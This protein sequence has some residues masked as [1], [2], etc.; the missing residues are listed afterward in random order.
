MQR[1]L[2]LTQVKHKHINVMVI[3]QMFQS[4]V[5]FGITNTMAQIPGFLTPVLVSEM[6]QHGTMEEWYDVFSLAGAV[7]TLGGVTY[8][9][10]GSS[11]TQEW[12][13]VKTYSTEVPHEESKLVLA[14]NV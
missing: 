10:W 9:V 1:L 5:L 3:Q 6:T 4:G 14:D 13:R 2:G 11:E 12:A 8:L 7:L